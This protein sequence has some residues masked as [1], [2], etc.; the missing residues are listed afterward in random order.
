MTVRD[1]KSSIAPKHPENTAFAALMIPTSKSVMIFPGPFLPAGP[2]PGGCI[3]HC[4]QHFGVVDLSFGWQ[5]N[6]YKRHSSFDVRIVDSVP[7][8]FHR[9]QFGEYLREY[10]LCRLEYAVEKPH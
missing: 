1:G 5:Q 2:E 7:R 3:L 10:V 4:L 9:G 6:V 8:T